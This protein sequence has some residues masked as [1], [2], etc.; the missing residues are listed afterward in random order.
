[1]VTR[2]SSAMVATPSDVT[3]YGAVGDGVTNDTAAVQACI[4]ATPNGTIYFPAGTFKL[5]GV[6]ISD[7]VHITGEGPSATFIK[8]G[9][10]TAVV[11]NITTTERVDVKELTF[12]PFV[13]ATKQTSGAYI[14]ISP[15]SGFAHD[16]VIENVDF[17]YANVGVHFEN[18]NI[19]SMVG[20][21]HTNYAYGVRVENQDTPDAG[22][23]TI[24]ECVFDAG[25]ATGVAIDQRSSG[26]LRITNNKILNGDYGYVGQYESGPSMTSI[27]LISGNS[28]ESQATAAIALNSSGSTTFSYVLIDANQFSV[29]ASNY[30]ILV[31]DPGYDYIDSML[32]G[33]NIFNL[34][35]SATAIYLTRGSRIS[36]LPNLIS[37]N[38]TSEVGINFGAN[39]GDAVVYQQDIQ[40]CTTNYGGTLTNVTWAGWGSQG[41]TETDDTDAAYGSMYSSG[42]TA[43]TFS[44][45]FPVAPKVDAVVATSD[46]GGVS[47]IVEDVTVS[48]FNLKILGLVN[49]GT[50][51]ARWSATL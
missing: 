44:P 32:I 37:G 8:A 48:G 29:T 5:A 7:S 4:D 3:F 15:A 47:T 45:A 11:F 13:T 26:G 9:S 33:S 43:V 19:W 30:G 25:G 28:M 41:G 10:A 50:V 49:G 24:T 1:M 21:Y 35:N 18:A 38:G 12:K 16:A 42:A 22:D 17:T 51:T 31:S 2:V 46:D 34:G 14:K 39:F 40:D 27:L 20:C 6:T 23:S 36:I